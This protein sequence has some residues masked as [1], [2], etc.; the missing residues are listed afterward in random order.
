MNFYVF[1]FEIVSYDKYSVCF[2]VIVKVENSWIVD[3]FYMLIKLEI[4]FFW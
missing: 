1:D 3:E 4:F 2:I